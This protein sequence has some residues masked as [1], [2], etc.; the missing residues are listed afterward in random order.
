MAAGYRSRPTPSLAATRSVRGVLAATLAVLLMSACATRASYQRALGR[1]VP[2]SR[3]AVR[4]GRRVHYLDTREPGLP[5]VIVHGFA[6][7]SYPFECLINAF[8]AGFRIIAPDLPGHGFSDPLSGE[9]TMEAMVGFLDAFTRGIGLTRFALAGSSMGANIA[10]HYAA[11][12]PSRVTGLVLLSPVGLV[13]QAGRAGRIAG[14]PG[15]VRILSGFV[16]PCAVRRALRWA[17]GGDSELV[18]PELLRAYG[19]SVS[20]RERRACLRS[21]VRNIIAGSYLEETL[22][23]IPQPVLL[24]AGDRDPLVKP[25]FVEKFRR[26]LIGKE[27]VIF[28]GGA[29]LLHQQFP[30]EVAGLV[31]EFVSTDARWKT[32]RLRAA[33]RLR[34]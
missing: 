25:P 8:P 33:V 2:E 23:R 28:S 26:L 18:T 6:A 19:L 31:A 7:Y 11:A 22:P 13:G 15:L 14:R 17:A 34:R 10:A 3:W 20:T 5:L 30:V 4:D 9:Y 32:P 21:V 27:V 1:A 29:H 12:Y 16:G 24:I